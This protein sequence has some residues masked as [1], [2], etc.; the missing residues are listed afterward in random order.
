MLCCLEIELDNGE[1]FEDEY[2]VEATF[3]N[4]AEIF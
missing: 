4:Y 3:Y 2:V 1:G